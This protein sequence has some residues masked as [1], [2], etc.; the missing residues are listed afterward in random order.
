MVMPEK[1]VLATVPATS[2]RH[3]SGPPIKLS[4]SLTDLARL[5][6]PA[7]ATV[8]GKQSAASAAQNAG[9]SPTAATYL[10]DNASPPISDEEATPDDHRAHAAPWT[11]P[12]DDSCSS[13]VSAEDAQA[14]SSAL[15]V[16]GLREVPAVGSFDAP[17]LAL[18][19]GAPDADDALDEKH[20]QDSAQKSAVR[21]QAWTKEEDAKLLELVERH[22]P[23]NWSRI[24]ADLPS[25]IGK[26]CRERWHNHLSPAVKKEG[27]TAEEDQAIMEAV[28]EHGTKWAHIVKLIPGRTDNAIKNR[29][30]STT[31]KMVRVQRRCGGLV[32]GLGEVDFN[33]MDAAAIA[34]HLLAHGVTAAAAAPPKPPAKRRLTLPAKEGKEGKEASAEEAD[35]ADGEQRPAKKARAGARKK[36]AAPALEDGL[37]LLRAATFRTAT[38]ALMEAAAAA[39][40]DASDAM[41]GADE[42]AEEHAAYAYEAADDDD[43]A[44]DDAP[45]DAGVRTAAP[46]AS[47][48]LFPLD[49]LT[50]LA[51]SS[52]T[53]SVEAPGACRSPRM[54]EAAIGMASAFGPSRAKA[55]VI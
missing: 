39:D 48:S 12:R 47:D 54:L 10:P 11:N 6:E 26:Q 34:K 19:A 1:T 3:L 7:I 51:H 36:V 13:S 24:A 31:R 33:A 35:D 5:D 20:G 25:R 42:D 4:I 50:L 14:C 30:N 8:I 22:G 41:N 53:L 15:P 37:A 21:K 44:D 38:N 32:P 9:S 2:A 40:G 45:A 29:W 49:A 27:F 46:S 43:D 23:S 52:S 18:A 55:L 16:A 17:L 28:A